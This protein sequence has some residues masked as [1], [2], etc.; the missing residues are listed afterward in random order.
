MPDRAARQTAVCASVAMIVVSFLYIVG[1]RYG[2]FDYLEA[3][4]G[5]DTKGR[6]QLFA[7][8]AP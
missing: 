6:A 7:N 2:L 3:Q 8:V 4:L 1:I 5:L